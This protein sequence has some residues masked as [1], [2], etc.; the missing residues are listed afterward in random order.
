MDDPLPSTRQRD[1][2]AAALAALA[3]ILGL[4]SFAWANRH[5]EFPWDGPILLVAASF[6]LL[7]ALVRGRREASE[8]PDV[9]RLGFGLLAPVAWWRLLAFGASLLVAGLLLRELAAPQP[10]ASYTRAV[11]LWL[12][13]IATFLLAV[14][15]P[16]RRPRE[17][18]SLWWDVNRRSVMLLGA[19]VLV[20]LGLRVWALGTLPE[21]L[22][23]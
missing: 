11:L 15:P 21:T 14:A 23:G 12:G 16:V 20:A 7:L 1:L 2:W 9:S 22:G 13:S 6:L 18:W 10:P 17:E 19:I 3:L 5:P 4:A 8:P